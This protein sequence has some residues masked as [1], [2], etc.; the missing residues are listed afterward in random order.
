MLVTDVLKIPALKDMKIVAGETGSNR[1]VE[2][3]NMMDAPDIILYIK[4]N[5]FL[6]TTG[7][8]F[9]DQ[10]SLLTELVKAMAD[11][12]C[13]ALGVKTKRYLEQIPDD[14]IAIAN[15][16]E[17][18]I[19]EIP[20]SI[21]LGEIVYQSFGVIL[22]QRTDELTYAMEIHKKFTQLVMEGKGVNQLLSALSRLIGYP[23][24]LINQHLKPLAYSN[25]QT[26]LIA[27]LSTMQKRGY[28]FPI[29]PQTNFSFSMISTR[30]T[31]SAFRVYMGEGRGG[32]LLVL[33]ELKGHGRL[34][35]LVIEQA[36]NVLSF[37]LMKETALNQFNRSIRND[38]FYHFLEGTYSSETEIINR[39]KE[40]TLH[41]TDKYI[42]VTG[43]L[44]QMNA[45]N[46]FKKHQQKIELIFEFVEEELNESRTPIHFFTKGEQCILLYATNNFYD[47]VNSLLELVLKEIQQKVST[48]YNET[49]SFG[50]S[51][52]K[53]WN[54]LEENRIYSILSDEGY[55]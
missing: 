42:C 34:N 37:A 6:I 52:F 27:Y 44:D 47:E 16:L 4:P 45:E 14:V 30:Q 39:A 20:A 24:V 41:H 8:H 40:F 3:V 32:Y 31:F 50:V 2:S 1:E 28:M 19:I 17:L 29:D 23:S 12:D 26:N 33:D 7:Y 9:K 54:F 51:C 11:K 25:P 43:K 53:E 13:A 49:I 36:V 18:P 15:E 35:S 5:E 46:G 55:Y 21:T 10:P 22:D 48:Y 38:F